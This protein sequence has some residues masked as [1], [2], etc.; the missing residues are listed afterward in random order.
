MEIAINL[1]TDA[2]FIPGGVYDGTATKI[3]IESG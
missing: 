2:E 3:E 1:V